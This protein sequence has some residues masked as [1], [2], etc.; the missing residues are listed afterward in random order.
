MKSLFDLAMDL[1]RIRD[2]LEPIGKGEIRKGR[3]SS[4]DIPLEPGMRKLL[5]KDARQICGL[6]TPQ[7]NSAI[8]QIL[9]HEKLYRQALEQLEEWVKRIRR[10][11]MGDYGP[12]L[13]EIFDTEAL[14]KKIR[15]GYQT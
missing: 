14:V 15:E 2:R 5:L 3:A 1:C 7:L 8:N 11:D 9:E 4:G 6:Q 13:D 12:M 10:G